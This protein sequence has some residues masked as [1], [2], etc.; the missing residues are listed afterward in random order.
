VIDL[1]TRMIGATRRFAAEIFNV[2][3]GAGYSVPELFDMMKR[4]SEQ[5]T[6]EAVYDNPEAFWDRYPALFQGAFPLLRSRV[7]KEVFKYSVGV[8][9]KAASEFGWVPKVDIE[10]G[11]R[12]VLLDA[13]RRLATP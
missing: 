10:T 4:M 13:K 7:R 11:L 5:P 3:S 9:Q 12:S 6:L 8:N 1:L 2:A